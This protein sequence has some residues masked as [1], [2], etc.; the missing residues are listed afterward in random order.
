M[1]M[2]NRTGASQIIT[3]K[4]HSKKKE[5]TGTDLKK[6]LVSNNLPICVGF[7]GTDVFERDI[8]A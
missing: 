6:L 8:G 4:C 3:G 5:T 2:G 1:I 7:A